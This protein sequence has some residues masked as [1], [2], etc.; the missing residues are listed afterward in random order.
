MSISNKDWIEMVKTI[1]TVRDDIKEGRTS[2]Y[3]EDK[4]DEVF[5]SLCRVKEFLYD[6][7]MGI[8]NE[9]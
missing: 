4:V 9:K 7:K 2:H 1:T 6:Y 5:Q 3:T 8:D